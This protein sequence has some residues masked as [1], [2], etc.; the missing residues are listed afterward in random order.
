MLHFFNDFFSFRFFFLLTLTN[1]QC[2][3]HRESQGRKLAVQS[4]LITL[5]AEKNT[6]E[7]VQGPGCTVWCEYIKDT[8]ENQL[9]SGSGQ[10]CP[11]WGVA[12]VLLVV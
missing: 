12:E 8:L 4:E 5:P 2:T 1:G 7:P 9:S 3:V 10:T 6:V 11:R